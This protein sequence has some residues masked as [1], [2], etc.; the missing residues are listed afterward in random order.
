MDENTRQ[1]PKR[2]SKARAYRLALDLFRERKTREAARLLDAWVEQDPDN[3]EAAFLRQRIRVAEVGVGEDAG[4]ALRALEAAGRRVGQSAIAL[5]TAARAWLAAGFADE[6]VRLA[7]E[8][9]EHCPAE[10]KTGLLQVLAAAY[11]RAEHFLAA[12]KVIEAG[13]RRDPDNPGLLMLGGQLHLLTNRF[14]PARGLL[15]KVI[16]I[17]PENIAALVRLTACQLHLQLYEEALETSAR[18]MGLRPGNLQSKAQRVAALSHLGRK[19]EAWAEIEPLLASHRESLPVAN[20]FATLAGGTGRAAEA[21]DM[22]RNALD[23]ALGESQGRKASLTAELHTLADIERQLGNHD[24][25]MSLLAKAKAATE[26]TSNHAG[27]VSLLRDLR[28]AANHV[29]SGSHPDPGLDDPQPVLIV[30]LPRSGTTLTEQILGNHHAVLP[31][32]ELPFL[33]LGI[34]RHE[35]R[36]TGEGA[37]YP[38][39]LERM[40]DEEARQFATDYR[41][42]A[43]SHGTAKEAGKPVAD[44]R[45]F[46]DKLPYNYL[47]IPVFRRIFPKAKVIFCRRNPLDNLL[48]CYFLNFQAQFSFMFQL[49]DLG[50]LYRWHDWLMRHYLDVF[51]D[52]ILEI[53]YER[54]VA[55]PEG[56][57]RR[58]L[59]WLGLDWDPACLEYHRNSRLLRTA[60][61]DQANRPVYRSSVG[62]FQPCLGHLGA[63][64]ATL[65]PRL[66][67]DHLVFSP[68]G[69]GDELVRAEMPAPGEPP[70]HYELPDET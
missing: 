14:E 30:G 12:G 70:D 65:G 58:A 66:T 22:L 2:I 31:L 21:R 7:K 34:R 49:D 43:L 57:A 25:A 16:G 64:M 62:R 48:S 68:N 60:S 45:L 52:H 24:E 28:A 67:A 47:H 40:T 53:R 69:D 11:L 39:F 41:E 54:L 38:R 61:W 9:L 36:T 15:A 19:D 18:V 44:S 56:E 35:A 50:F 59:E 26:D 27:F 51:R 63:T 8:T 3:A 4:P 33:A 32:G 29:C 1:T 6:A 20:S 10:E 46:L 17:E 13:L 37:A 42:A 5:A 55:D 23:K